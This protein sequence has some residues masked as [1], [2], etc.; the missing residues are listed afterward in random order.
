MSRPSDPMLAWLRKLVD[1][2]GLN[3]AQLAE[4]CGLPR[5]R[6]RKVL[7][8]AES[9]LVDEFVQI[10]NALQ[11]APKD[12][13]LPDAAAET[14]EEPPA[15][16][17]EAVPK[18]DP[19]GNHPQQLFRVAFGLGCDFTFVADADQLE[20]SGVPRHVLSEFRGRQL[21]IRLDAAYHAYNAPRY[22]E[23]GVTLSLSFD[24]V[25][26]CR[27]PWASIRGIFFQAPFATA[28]REEPPEPEPPPGRPRLRLVE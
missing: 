5:A 1:T 12:V 2:K 8:G 15:P 22:D 19:W 27:F 13:G 23:A 26:E 21:P 17:A 16:A 28:A 18:V 3:T 14:P 24:S 6:V 10:A 11:I 20:E 7:T 9:M 4:K 25:Y